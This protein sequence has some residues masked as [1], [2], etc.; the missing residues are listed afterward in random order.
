M[1][2]LALWLVTPKMLAQKARGQIL[3]RVTD[4]SG[5]V[6]VGAHVSAINAATNVE[7]ATTTKKTVDYVLPLLFPGTYSVSGLT[8]ARSTL[9]SGGSRRRTSCRV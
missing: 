3:G 6:V 9:P 5:A 4:L 7:S 1:S 2:P 8:G